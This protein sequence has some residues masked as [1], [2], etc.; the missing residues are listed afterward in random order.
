MIHLY[1]EC[2][3][4]VFVISMFRYNACHIDSTL[5]NEQNLMPQLQPINMKLV[6]IIMV[7]IRINDIVRCFTHKFVLT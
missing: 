5:I 7:S 4:N 1:H 2:G 6:Y 3:L